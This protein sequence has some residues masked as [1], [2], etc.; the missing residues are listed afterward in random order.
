MEDL[1]RCIRRA[2]PRRGH[3][4]KIQFERG[5]NEGS[6]R[7]PPHPPEGGGGGRAREGGREREKI[8]DAR[9]L[10]GPIFRLIHLES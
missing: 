5:G 2:I 1:T 10:G 9:S 3:F 7:E 8:I 6:E 4:F